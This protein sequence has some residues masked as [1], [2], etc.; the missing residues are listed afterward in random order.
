MTNYFVARTI[1][2][3]TI[4]TIVAVIIVIIIYNYNKNAKHFSLSGERN[5]VLSRKRKFHCRTQTMNL[6]TIQ[7]F[8][9]ELIYLTDTHF[10]QCS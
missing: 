10:Y 9:I 1:H 8:Y 3:V 6:I 2:I 7:V 5:K 4:I